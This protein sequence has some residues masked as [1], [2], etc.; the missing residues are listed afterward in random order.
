MSEVNCI[1]CHDKGEVCA[2]CGYSEDQC[3][4]QPDAEFYE[5]PE[6]CPDCDTE[7]E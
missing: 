4:C 2:S 1:R 6:P 5:E 7:A 3:D